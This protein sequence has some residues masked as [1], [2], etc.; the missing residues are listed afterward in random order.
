MGACSAP[1]QAHG[2]GIGNKRAQQCCPGAL[3]HGLLL[4][5]IEVY[6]SNF[7]N[8]GPGALLCSMVGDGDQQCC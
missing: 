4:L 7:C 2:G 5:L 8:L 3:P 6:I 1:V